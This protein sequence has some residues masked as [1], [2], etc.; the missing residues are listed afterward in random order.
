MG[1]KFCASALGGRIR[2]LTAGEF[3]QNIA[4]IIWEK[5]FTCVGSGEP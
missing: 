2:N 1:C 4:R 3:Y 5:D